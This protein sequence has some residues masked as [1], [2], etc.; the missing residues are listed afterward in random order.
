ML[1]VSV[2]GMGRRGGRNC[3]CTEWVRRGGDAVGCCVAGDA[4]D[5]GRKIDKH[6]VRPA[7]SY[8]AY[9]WAAGRGQEAC[10]EVVGVGWMCGVTRGV[11]C[12]R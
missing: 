5:A 12:P 8:G 4:D 11:C 6:V 2:R 1:S 10:L 3:N 9:T 7:P